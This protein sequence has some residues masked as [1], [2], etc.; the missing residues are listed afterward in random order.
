MNFRLNALVFAAALLLACPFLCAAQQQKPV[1]DVPMLFRGATPAVE[2]SVNGK[3]KFL[4][5]IDTGAQGTARVDS[6]LVERLG[7]KVTGQVNA[8]DG[9]GQNVRSLDVV[10]LDSISIGDV[11][12]RDVEALTIRRPRCR[13]LTASWALNSSKSIC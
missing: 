4:F 8:S 1:L 7:L 6:T 12:F 13:T 3:G 9:S 11:Q 5:A 10:K 2:V